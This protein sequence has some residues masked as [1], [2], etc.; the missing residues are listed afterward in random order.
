MQTQ[1]QTN[2]TQFEFTKVLLNNLSLF[3]LAPTTKLVLLYLSNFYNPQKP[4]YPRQETISQTIGISLSS[5]KRAV[6][7]LSELGLI[8]VEMKWN[9]N[10]V[11]TSKIFDILKLT[12]SKDQNETKLQVKLN[13]HDKTI[14]KKINKPNNFY[15]N[16]E[17]PKYPP[18]VETI[19]TY[20]KE[21]ETSVSP[22]SFD[23]ETAIEFY[24][25]LPEFA[26]NGYFAKE[27]KKKWNLC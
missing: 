27:L 3:D 7:E 18:A 23:R 1:K 14:N 9:N 19:Q 15:K 24:Q 20:K 26:K 10:Y 21:R 2:L 8:L 13:P 12:L 11:F 22:L 4:A 25:K 5:V 6:K 16:N 17:A